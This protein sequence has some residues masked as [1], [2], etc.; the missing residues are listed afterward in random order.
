MVSWFSSLSL[1]ALNHKNGFLRV[2]NDQ[3]SI[4]TCIYSVKMKWHR[5]E[6]VFKNRQ[7]CALDSTAGNCRI[8]VHNPNSRADWDSTASLWAHGRK[9]RVS[10][11]KV[12]HWSQFGS[13]GSVTPNR[14]NQGADFLSNLHRNAYTWYDNSRNYMQSNKHTWRDIQEHEDTQMKIHNKQVLEICMSYECVQL[15]LFK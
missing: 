5:F 1:N 8:R 4:E 9:T 10:K 13:L 14:K 11:I 3:E 12:T 15:N 6:K 7:I 2:R